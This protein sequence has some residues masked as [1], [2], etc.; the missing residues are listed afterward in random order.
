MA[1]EQK[2]N[3]IIIKGA[4]ARTKLLEGFVAARETVGATYGPKGTNVRI[5]K[6]YGRSLLTR[7]GVTVAR[8][9]YFKDRAKNLGAG[10]VME[11]S[12]TTNRIAG[13]GTT[14]TVVLASYLME[15]GV[16]AISAGQHPMEV[17]QQLLDDSYV[18]LDRLKELTQPTKKSQLKQVATVSSGD[19]A[20]GEMI[21]GAIEYVGQNGGI[22]T[23]KALISEVQREY[24]DGYYLQSGFTALQAGKKEI[25]N[26][27][28]VVAIRRLSSAADAIE[29]LTAVAK[30]QNLEQ[31]QMLRVLFIGNIEDAAYNTIVENINR[32][33]LDAVIIKT[34]PSFGEMGKQLLEDIA[35]YSG[36]APLVESM[37]LKQFNAN[38]VGVVDKVVATRSDATLF[39]DNKTEALLARVDA[40][41]GQLEVE[42]VDPIREKLQQ[43]LAGIEG[44]VAIFKI[45]GASETTKEEVEFRVED[46]ILAT[47]AADKH[48][49]VPGGG[50]TLYEL[51]KCAVSDTYQAALTDTLGLLLTNAN[52]DPSLAVRDMASGLG[53]NLR[54]GSAMVDVV[55][56]GILDPALVVEQTIKNATDVASNSL[57]T[58][59]LILFEDREV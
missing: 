2:D 18:L 55:K 35:L 43:R 20:L 17:K 22:I 30:A 33:T 25:I 51:S 46:A 39:A 48:G 56:E 44:K 31:G 21:A 37:N 4:E 29:I 6:T 47:K 8:E 10:A 23:E 36:C 40:I 45:G 26:P 32:G 42:D 12:E 5:E 7:D 11:A 34:P 49:V 59:T 58:E 13:D 14:A 16:Q 15:H 3:K 50:V 53:Y 54:K 27:A 41:K 24:V 38:H 57:T 19:P 9:T 52:L 1:L 28:V